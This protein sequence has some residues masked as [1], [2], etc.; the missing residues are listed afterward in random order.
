MFPCNYSRKLLRCQHPPSLLIHGNRLSFYGKH[1]KGTAQLCSKSSEQPQREHLISACTEKGRSYEY[2]QWIK[3]AY[4]STGII[5]CL[6]R[7]FERFHEVRCSGFMWAK[8]VLLNS[9]QHRRDLFS[10]PLQGLVLKVGDTIIRQLLVTEVSESNGLIR[11]PT[12]GYGGRF[13]D[14]ITV[15]MHNHP[16]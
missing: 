13:L 4:L 8:K 1:F 7:A 11:D 15:S 10:I 16:A 3:T 14:H 6:L 5:K 12:E 9:Q 2:F